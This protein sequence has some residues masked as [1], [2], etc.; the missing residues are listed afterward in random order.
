MGIISNIT[1]L[2]DIVSVS[3]SLCYAIRV[4]PLGNGNKKFTYSSIACLLSCFLFFVF[5]FQR[6]II[7]QEH[8]VARILRTHSFSEAPRINSKN[9][10]A[11]I[12]RQSPF[13]LPIPPNHYKGYHECGQE[14]DPRY[15]G[16]YST[17]CHPRIQ[18]LQTCCRLHSQH[19]CGWR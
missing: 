10:P 11:I 19:L 17:S 8:S 4:E 3:L 18:S 13:L 16:P 14:Q 2:L 5:V 6:S 7:F 15:H 1:Y 9:V 12:M